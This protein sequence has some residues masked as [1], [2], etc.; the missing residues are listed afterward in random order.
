MIFKRNIILLGACILY[1]FINYALNNFLFED[2]I[3]TIKGLESEHQKVNEKYI[4]AQIL[5]KGYEE[6]YTIFENNLAVKKN[7]DKTKEASMNFL[8]KL[9]NIFEK[10][11]IELEQIIPQKKE[12][13]GAN[14]IKIPYKL[15]FQCD[16]EKLGQIVTELE[17]NSRLIS[18]DQLLI[19]NDIEK[20]RSQG[21]TQMDILNQDIE[22]K[23][24]TLTLMKAKSK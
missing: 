3:D 21:I 17:S 9:T 8:N 23:I 13:Q 14:L 18:I 19:K 20:T 4:Q 11:S 22:M 1:I 2:K 12:K 7:D 6:V 24:S 16:F 15:N 10:N 5:S